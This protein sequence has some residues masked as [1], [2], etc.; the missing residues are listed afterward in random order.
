M[1]KILCVVGLFVVLVLLPAQ[2][3]ITA[4]FEEMFLAPG[5]TID[6][7]FTPSTTGEIQLRLSLQPGAAEV[8][9]RIQRKG[10]AQPIAEKI[11]PSP[12]TLTATVGEA[13]V[14]KTF[15]LIVSNRSAQSLTGRWQLTFPR[16]YCKEITSE[17]RV[18]I[19][20]EAGTE[21]DDIHCYQLYSVLRSLPAK[22][23]RRLREIRAE[24]PSAFLYG[25][26][27]APCTALRLPGLR[28]GRTF[29]LVI[30]HEIGHT[31][32]FTVLSAQQESQWEQL[33]KQSGRDPD[34]FA[35]D[36]IDRSLY[37]MTNQYEDFAVTYSAYI[38]D[39][40]RYI[41]EALSRA[42]RAKTL[43]LEKFKL[44][45]ELFQTEDRQKVYI[46]RVGTEAPT[47]KIERA[48]VPLTAE[49][50]PDFSVQASWECFGFCP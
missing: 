36:P 10:Q 23:I 14:G 49:G 21:L 13:D 46:Y 18:R 17:F 50:L 28:A 35:P 5:A 6:Y 3:T 31:V 47:P 41:Q 39:T 48:L 4:F 37:A 34:H 44:V 16:V 20:Y 7:E 11:G 15:V 27:A 38:A 29:V 9:S 12:H 2:A 33:F 32:H 22:H 26:C 19:G 24:A 45:T 25:Y 30:Y 42:Q 40:Q 8:L 43:L 1:R